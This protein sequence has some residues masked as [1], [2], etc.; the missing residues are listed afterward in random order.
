MFIKLSV[1]WIQI[2]KAHKNNYY[3]ICIKSGYKL[4][5]IQTKLI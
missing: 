2:F 3:T 4:V 5:T 1:H